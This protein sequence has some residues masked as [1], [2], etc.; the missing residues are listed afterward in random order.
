MVGGE[1]DEGDGGGEEE[2]GWDWPTMRVENGVY[3]DVDV[4]GRGEGEEV[5][6]GTEDGSRGGG[7]GVETLGLA[8]GWEN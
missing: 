3:I 1:G 4:D 8:M 7:K 5:F 2:L 6:R